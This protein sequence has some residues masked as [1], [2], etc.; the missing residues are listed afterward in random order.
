[1]SYITPKAYYTE[2]ELLATEYARLRDAMSGTLNTNVE[3]VTKNI[4]TYTD[5][6]SDL[7]APILTHDATRDPAGS[8]ASDLGNTFSALGVKFSPTN[9]QTLAISYFSAAFRALNSH[10][11]G[12]TPIPTDQTQR[13]LAQYVVNY[14]IDPAVG[15]EHDDMSLFTHQSGLAYVDTTTQAA[16]YFSDNFVEMANKTGITYF[17]SGQDGEIYTSAYYA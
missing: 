2:A 3:T 1:M 5:D 7:N 17:N 13:T 11:V 15:A 10:V 6:D 12:K 4:V 14:K 9:S 16:Y 8:I